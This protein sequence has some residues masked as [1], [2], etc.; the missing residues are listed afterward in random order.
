MTA[1]VAPPG[2]LELFPPRPVRSAPPWEVRDAHGHVLGPIRHL[3][4]AAACAA[5]VAATEGE[6]WLVAGDGSA[7]HVDAA[8][9]VTP[10]EGWPATAG[11]VIGRIRPNEFPNP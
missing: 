7:C 11:R 3:T 9:T 2:Q 8:G 4:I 10:A 5:Q 1:V 6:A